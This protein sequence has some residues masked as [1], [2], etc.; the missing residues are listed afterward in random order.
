[1]SNQYRGPADVR[2]FIMGAVLTSKKHPSIG[3]VIAY[4]QKNE[5]PVANIRRQALWL[6]EIRWLNMVDQTLQPTAAALAHKEDWIEGLEEVLGRKVK[7]RLPEVDLRAVAPIP[8]Q[9][10]TDPSNPCVVLSPG[11]GFTGQIVIVG[12]EARR[13]TSRILKHQSNQFAIAGGES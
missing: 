5:F 13:L 12:D 4:A 10:S 6:V 7:Q 11:P 3:D 9:I 8:T 1:M 2:V